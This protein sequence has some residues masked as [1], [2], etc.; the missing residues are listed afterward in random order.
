MFPVWVP[1]IEGRY[2]TFLIVAESPTLLCLIWLRPRGQFC[3]PYPHPGLKDPSPPSPPA[4]PS[5][6]GGESWPPLA[7]LAASNPHHALEAVTSVTFLR[8]LSRPLLSSSYLL[9]LQVG[10]TGDIFKCSF[11]R[12]KGYDRS[13]WNEK[14]KK[15]PPQNQKTTRQVRS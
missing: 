11:F 6:G 5:R 8:R 10:L 12:G 15:N 4:P 7:D 9:R 3:L 14:K 2:V 13:L 1:Q